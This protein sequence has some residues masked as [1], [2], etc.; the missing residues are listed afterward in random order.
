MHCVQ[1]PPFVQTIHHF[2]LN[3]ADH[4]RA[5]TLVIIKWSQ[6]TRN[7]TE[8][9]TCRSAISEGSFCRARLRSS[10]SGWRHRSDRKDP[11]G[12]GTP[13]GHCR[14]RVRAR[15]PRAFKMLMASEFCPL[16]FCLLVDITSYIHNLCAGNPSD[17]NE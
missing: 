11:K 12:Q 6:E 14:H 1:R 10:K 2:Y 7:W 8:I 17:L 13:C 16:I 15:I 9:C 4:L 3:S 5:E